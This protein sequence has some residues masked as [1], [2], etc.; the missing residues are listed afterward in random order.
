MGIELR[1]YTEEDFADLY[2][3]D[4]RCFPPGIAY[5]KRM[6]RYFLR[7]PQGRCILARD[8]AALPGDGSLAGKGGALAGFMITEEEPPVG[9][10]L[11]L[12]VAE[13]YRRRGVG[14]Q[15]LAR[16]ENDLA[17]RGVTEFVMETSV[18]N[19][20]GVAFWQRHG[21]RSVGILPRYYLGT[22]DAYEMRK[23][24]ARP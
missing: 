2:A 3:L 18:E 20:A 19:A 17:S 13:E 23:N 24:I 12:D 7:M 21:F 1:G 9:H 15:L 4:Q 6:L 8:D 5:S 22:I 10:I 11:T 14:T 16:S